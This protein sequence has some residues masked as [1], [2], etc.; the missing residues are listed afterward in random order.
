MSELCTVS[1]DAENRTFTVV[2]ELS[3]DS[4]SNVL[5]ETADM[6][7]KIAEIN[8]DLKQVTRSDSA[9]LAVL[10]EWTRQAKNMKKEIHFHNLPVQMKAIANVTGVDEFLPLK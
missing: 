5:T 7:D 4:V 3:L 9:G 6:F 2:G 10:I 1:F 8:I